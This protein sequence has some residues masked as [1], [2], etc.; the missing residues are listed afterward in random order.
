MDY[1]IWCPVWKRKAGS[2]YSSDL[3]TE[4]HLFLLDSRWP[5]VIP[6][7]EF[8]I[9][10][11]AFNPLTEYCSNIYG[12]ESTR[13]YRSILCLTRKQAPCYLRV[14][15][16]CAEFTRIISVEEFRQLKKY[17]FFKFTHIIHFF[18]AL[19]FNSVTKLFI[20]CFILIQTEFLLIH[21]YTCNFVY[22]IVSKQTTINQH[23]D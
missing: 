12:L 15:I 22:S 10:I 17:I 6:V 21:T 23:Y 2:P 14:V 5:H 13:W 1:F 19:L 7:P 3:R 9:V 18:P 20:F 8:Q 16:Y 4:K 11:A